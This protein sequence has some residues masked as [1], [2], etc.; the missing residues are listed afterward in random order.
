MCGCLLHAPNRGPSPHPGMCPDWESNR[1]PF[2]SQARAQSTKAIPARAYNTIFKDLY[3][4]YISPI[5]IILF[6]VF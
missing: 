3:L 5:T 4:V 2:C 1:Q 6:V